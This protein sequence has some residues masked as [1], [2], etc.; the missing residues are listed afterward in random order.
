MAT[1]KTNSRVRTTNKKAPARKNHKK[2]GGGN[3]IWLLLVLVVVAGGILLALQVKELYKEEILEG[4]TVDGIDVSGMTQEGASKI[5][6][7]AADDRLKNISIIFRYNDKTWSFQAEDLE[8]TIETQAVVK[9][10]YETGKTSSV[11]ERFQTF[12]EVKSEG[13]AFKSSF[14]VDRQVL[15]D[16]LADVKKE[17]DQPMVEANIE[18]DPTG[19]GYDEIIDPEFDEIAAMF[20][21][22]EGRVGYAMNYDKALQDLNTQ[23]DS[24]WSADI[25]LSVVESYPTKNLETLKEYTTLVFHSSSYLNSSKRQNLNRNHN[26]KM[27]IDFY[28]GLVVMPGEI[29]SYNTLLGKRTLA[30]GWLEAPTIARDKTVKDEVGG[31]ICQSATAIF[32]VAFTAGAKIIE[33]N[34]HS[35]AAYYNDFGYAMDAMVNWGTSDFIFEN[36]SDY[37]MFINTYFWYSPLTSLPGYVDVDIYTMPQKDDDGNILHIRAETTEVR[38]EPPNPMVYEPID[39]ATALEKFPDAVWTPDP[40]L[41]LL[42]YEQITPRALVEYTVDR[43]WFKDCEE[44]DVIGVWTGGV[45]VKREHSHN[46]I[47]KAITGKTYTK[48]MPTAPP[49]PTP[50]PEP[51]PDGGASG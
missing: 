28:K 29:V 20:T 15:V 48:P 18:F 22:T 12:Q 27:A 36:N 6:Q 14:V 46:Y 33:S 34:P 24:G 43:V 8:A 32:N 10:A 25:T 42:V 19:I 30:S 11:I 45:E 17:I 51:T 47:Y 39:E 3:L 40:T 26:I 44:T 4:I 21:I 50:T 2:G 5:V 35:W 9:E 38:R 16:A 1:K 31:G 49:T 13:L 37:P 23:L 41:N 7:E